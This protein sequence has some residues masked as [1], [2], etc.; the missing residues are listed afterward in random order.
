MKLYYHPRSPYS[1]KALLAFHE[2]QVAFTPAILRPNDAAE[3]AELLGINPLGKLPILVLDDGWK[4]PESTIIIEYLEGHHGGAR[5]IPADRD[6]ARQTRFHDRLA[7]LYVNEPVQ[8]IFW[9]SM[10]P[11]AEREPAR[12]AAA[13]ERLDHMYAAFDAHLAKRTWIMGDSFT[14]ADCALLPPLGYARMLH[15]F[16]RH[17]NLVAYAGRGAERPS[18]VEV[19]A[20]LAPYLAK[21]A[22]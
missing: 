11:E 18:M 12:V 8:T 21:A 13:R 3:R 16:D 10:K 15:P 1:Q 9:D 2:K 7:D 19:Q 22:S 6:Q 4:I 17:K 20:E 14:M 5:L